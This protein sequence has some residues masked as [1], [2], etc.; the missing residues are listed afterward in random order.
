MPNRSFDSIMAAIAG[1][2]ARSCRGPGCRDGC[3]PPRRYCPDCRLARRRRLIDF[4]RR[5][6]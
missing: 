3:R 6:R 1:P 2:P 4:W 5:T